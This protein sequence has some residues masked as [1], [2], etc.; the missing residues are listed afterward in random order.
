MRAGRRRAA[1]RA[2]RRHG[3]V[4]R[5]PQHQLHQRL[6]GRLRVLRLRPG[7]ALARRL[8]AST[9]EDF[10][11]AGRAR[12]STSARPRSACRAASIPT[13]RSRTTA[14]WL[15]LAK[16]V[17]PQLHLHAY[18]PMEV[19]L[20]V[21]A[22]RARARRRCSSYLRECG[23]GSTPGTAAEVLARRR[24][25]ADLAEQAAGRRAGSR[26]SRPRHRAGLR[27]TVD[28]D[29]RPHRG[30]VGAGRAHAR[31]ARAAGAHR[32]DHRVRA[33]Q[34]HPVPHAARAHARDRGDLARGEPQAHR[35][36]PARARARRSRTCRR[37]G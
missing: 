36:L 34:L 4:R 35:G 13:T 10:A 23:L 1:R 3:D 37:A 20:H 30:A 31:R 27:S 24:A 18:S 16:E 15:R 2:R 29:V 19:A 26:S 6:L 21:R 17:A 8:R 11:G 14:R 25:P 12:R 9:E 32:R 22:L 7:Q 33:A 5:Q 28:R